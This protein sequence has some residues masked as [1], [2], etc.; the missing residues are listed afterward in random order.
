M[1]CCCSLDLVV[2][3]F[4]WIF[5]SI[6]HFLNFSLAFIFH[7]QTTPCFYVLCAPWI[8]KETLIF[9]FYFAH[10]I[11]ALVLEIDMWHLIY[12]Q[13]FKLLQAYWKCH[14]FITCWYF[15]MPMGLMLPFEEL[16]AYSHLVVCQWYLSGISCPNIILFTSIMVCNTRFNLASNVVVMLARW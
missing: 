13:H 6:F 16:K 3:Y 1:S 14:I 9:S 12:L 8:T 4:Y 2:S 10:I 15:H 11:Q 5:S 7:F